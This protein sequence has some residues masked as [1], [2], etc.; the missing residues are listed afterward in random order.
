MLRRNF[1]YVKHIKRFIELVELITLLTRSALPYV[2]FLCSLHLPLN[3]GIDLIA[4]K[5]P[6]NIKSVLLN[7]IFVEPREQCL[8]AVHHGITDRVSY[9]TFHR[10]VH[11]CESS[12]PIGESCYVW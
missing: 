10:I 12:S 4:V 7:P 11:I 6:E 2:Y 1:C 8:Y 3:D 5:Q 9:K